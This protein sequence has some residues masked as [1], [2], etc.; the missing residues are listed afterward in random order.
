MPIKG[1]Q[2]YHE[3][4]MDDTNFIFLVL[5]D[6]TS[7]ISLFSVSLMSKQSIGKLFKVVFANG[8][9]LMLCIECYTSYFMEVRTC[10]LRV[11]QSMRYFNKKK[12][13]YKWICLRSMRYVPVS[14]QGVYLIQ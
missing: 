2:S 9:T 10:V 14:T 13:I 11:S 12:L 1:K 3:P 5:E 7:L 4:K 8:C 6:D